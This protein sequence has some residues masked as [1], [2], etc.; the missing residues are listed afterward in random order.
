MRSVQPLEGLADRLHDAALLGDVSALQ[1][2]VREL[3][4]A[5]DA[6]RVLAEQIA[7]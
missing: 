2:L 1:A 7:G 5:T 4:A 3:T 6:D